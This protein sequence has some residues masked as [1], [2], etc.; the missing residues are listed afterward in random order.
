MI[1]ITLQRLQNKSFKPCLEKSFKTSNI[2]CAHYLK[3]QKYSSALNLQLVFFLQ[4]T[5]K[6]QTEAFIGNVK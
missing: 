6:E 2:T 4:N 3:E 5:T 1:H